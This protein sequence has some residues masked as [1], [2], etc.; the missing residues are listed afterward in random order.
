MCNHLESSSAVQ[1]LAHMSGPHDKDM[2]WLFFRKF[3]IRITV[4]EGYHIRRRYST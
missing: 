1:E 3:Q 2:T 4:E